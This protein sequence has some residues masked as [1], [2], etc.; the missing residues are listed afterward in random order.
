MTDNPT[1]PSPNKKAAAPKRKLITR[2]RFFKF[3]AGSAALGA[4]TLVYATQFAPY[5]LTIE[6]LTVPIPNLPFRWRNQ[7]IIHL[8]DLHCG[9]RVD[10]AHIIRAFQMSA[11]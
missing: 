10:S 5:H 9:P 8:S 6:N 7:K 2:R 3:L 1:N 11:D 4:G